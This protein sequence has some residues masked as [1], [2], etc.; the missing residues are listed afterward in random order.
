MDTELLR[1]R[2]CQLVIQELDLYENVMPLMASTTPLTDNFLQRI[3]TLMWMRKLLRWEGQQYHTIYSC[4]VT[5]V[6]RLWDEMV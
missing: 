6:D 3:T 4:N 5:Y 1:I 2:P